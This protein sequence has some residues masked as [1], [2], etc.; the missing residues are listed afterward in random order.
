M[1]PSASLPVTDALI[2]PGRP[3]PLG[4]TPDPGGVNFAVFSGHAS[5]IQLC[6]FDPTGTHELRRVDLPE[7]T[8]QIFH[9]YLPGIGPGQVY[10]FRAHGR[11]A[12]AEGH[13]FN[14]AR[15]LLDPYTRAA[16]GRLAWDGPNIV[17][18]ADPYTLDERDSAPYVP[19]SVVTALRPPA[20]DSERPRVPWPETV[21]YEAH[22]KGLT[23]LHPA[24]PARLRGTY[25]G[26]AH[27]AVIDHHG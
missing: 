13:R 15:L 25:R 26:L 23:R 10:G 5:R 1:P 6:L 16:T 9:G 12:P 18:E 17:N 2:C 27:L 4:A 22:V 8:D 7:R 19:K 11:W 14:E 21:L 24:L 20:P 3:W